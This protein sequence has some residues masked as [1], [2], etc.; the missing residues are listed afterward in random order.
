MVHTGADGLF[1]TAPAPMATAIGPTGV[2]TNTATLGGELNTFG[3]TGSYRFD[4]WS[5]DSA[6][7]VSIAERR[8]QATLGIERVSA[9]LTGLPAGETVCRAADRDQQRHEHASATW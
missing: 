8:P 3:L 6:Y 5:L 2:T 4:V 1:R 9:A 7:A